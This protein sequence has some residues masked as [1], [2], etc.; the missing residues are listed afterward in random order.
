MTA[1]KLVVALSLALALATR[2]AAAPTVPYAFTP[3]TPARA[4]EV[5]A[6]FQA[7][8]QAIAA[9]MPVGTVLPFAG[10]TAPA[11]FLLCDGSTPSRAEYPAL[12]AV[13]KTKYGAGDGSTTFTL[14]D[15]RARFPV[16]A[17]QGTVD[18]LGHP[19]SNRPLASTGG[20]EAHTLTV[21]QMPAH[22]H[23]EGNVR[24]WSA[25]GN[26]QWPWDGTANNAIQNAQTGATGGGQS[27]PNVPPF[28]ALNWIIKT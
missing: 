22:T 13:I 3:S 10:D 16:G 8:L 2:A 12:F 28:V 17:G 9:A 11:G 15:L 19:L 24:F 26:W 1:R 18:D 5:N 14:P 6:N 7:V 20:R 21:D 23:D 27:H 4:A 25:S